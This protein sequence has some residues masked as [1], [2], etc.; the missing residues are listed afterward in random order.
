MIMADPSREHHGEYHQVKREMIDRYPDEYS[1]A[2]HS[3]LDERR[4]RLRVHSE[5]DKE[6]REK[7]RRS[8]FENDPRRVKH[9]GYR[10]YS[11]SAHKER[12]FSEDPSKSLKN[13]LGSERHH[14]EDTSSRTSSVDVNSSSA[15]PRS[16]RADPRSSSGDSR[17]SRVDPRSSSAD[18]RSSRVDPRSSSADPRSSKVDPRSSSADPRSSRVDPRSSSVDSRSST[19]DPRSSNADP[20]SSSADT[21]SVDGIK[22]K[23]SKKHHKHKPHDHE[24]SRSSRWD[25]CDDDHLENSRDSKRSR[26][27]Q[28]EKEVI[29]GSS[30]SRD[31]PPLSSLRIKREPNNDIEIVE[32]SNNKMRTQKRRMAKKSGPPPVEV[33]DLDEPPQPPPPST[34]IHQQQ[35]QNNSQPPGAFNPN[36]GESSRWSTQ[37]S[38]IPQEMLSLPPVRKFDSE[39]MVPEDNPP[40][41]LTPQ[42]T[43][44]QPPTE[45]IPY[46]YRPQEQYQQQYQ[47]RQ[48]VEHQTQYQMEHQSQNQVQ[49]Q[50]QSQVQYQPQNHVQHQTVNQMQDQ[51]EYQMQHQ[52]TY[53]PSQESVMD[54][55][56]IEEE[57][58]E[59]FER[60]PL[61]SIPSVHI[62]QIGG[63]APQPVVAKNPSFP[64][65]AMCRSCGITFIHPCKYKPSGN[66]QDSFMETGHL[67]K[68]KC[69]AVFLHTRSCKQSCG[70]SFVPDKKETGLM[71]Q[72]DR[73]H[74]YECHD[75]VFKFSVEQIRHMSHYFE[76]ITRKDG[77]L[78]EKGKKSGRDL[79]PILKHSDDIAKRRLIHE[80][81]TVQKAYMEMRRRLICQCN[82]G[83]CVVYH[84]CPPKPV[85][86]QTDDID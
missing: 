66:P 49:H 43:F 50:T 25:Q 32:C 26:L 42:E 22:R 73:I 18:P 33:V 6:R 38:I 53:H 69:S 40:P 27:N 68:C 55:Q 39:Y 13:G 48:Q 57:F 51:M 63:I 8:Y 3:Y 76:S 35:E 58:F 11:G 34:M 83:C 24:S 65:T 72:I 10:D 84:E 54:E 21:R 4:E 44:Y 75:C 74:K 85:D 15:D 81:P 41:P 80:P 64:V 45:P 86:E 59:E 67:H 12:E 2:L 47:E 30:A 29:G 28:N 36:S 7:H 20:R 17:S 56:P 1:N 61:A 71:K 5:Y 9:E 16:S 52:E 23:K 19:A 78:R 82:Q 79:T 14:R 31:R 46:H 62:P 70:K 37:I 60:K 77:T